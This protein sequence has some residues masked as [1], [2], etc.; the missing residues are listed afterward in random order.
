[1]RTDSRAGSRPA[2]IKR[3]TLRYEDEFST[4]GTLERGLLIT[5]T[6]GRSPVKAYGPASASNF[7]FWLARAG[8]PASSG[9]HCFALSPAKSRDK[10]I[11]VG[12]IIRD[13]LLLNT[14]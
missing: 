13:W 7:S 11:P 3:R 6:N 2:S 14:T 9:A 4:S 5:D 8:P 10:G 1:M 12:A